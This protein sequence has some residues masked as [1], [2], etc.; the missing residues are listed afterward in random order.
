[1]W[2]ADMGDEALPMYGYEGCVVTV[3]GW[4][5]DPW[6]AEDHAYYQGYEDGDL[7]C[8][9][10]PEDGYETCHAFFKTDPGV[11][12]FADGMTAWMWN[13]CGDD[14]GVENPDL[15]AMIDA[16]DGGDW[17]LT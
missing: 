16:C 17:G 10:I 13:D 2:H 7:I 3:G 14:Y 11:Y 6:G 9:W 5:Q 8:F 12:E 15:Q 1:M 4:Y